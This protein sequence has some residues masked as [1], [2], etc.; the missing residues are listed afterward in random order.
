[1]DKPVRRQTRPACSAETGHPGG[2]GRF[3]LV[4]EE[5][6][7]QRFRQDSLIEVLH[8]SQQVFGVLDDDVLRYVS[9]GLGLPP[10]R[11]Y[12]VATFYHLFRLTPR[13]DHTCT[14]CT[15]TACYV[16]GA[17]R[18]LA[19]AEQSAGARAG[20]TTPDGRITLETARCIG[21]CGLAPLVVFDGE[22][23]GHVSAEEVAD[24]L[25]GWVGHGP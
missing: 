4:D 7:R 15:G 13:G 3:R 20:E 17:E 1:M 19:V 5:L 10:S 25:K 11:V 23:A 18:V 24:R 22:V 14:V 6:K 21:S 2:D 12:G 8:R 9:R 16:K